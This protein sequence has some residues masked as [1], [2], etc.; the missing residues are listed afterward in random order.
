MR[1]VVLLCRHSESEGTF[2]FTINK[3]ADTKL[4]ELIEDVDPF[5]FP[6]LIGGP[7]QV[8]TLHYIHQYPDL[9]PDSQEVVDGVY[10]GG[11]FDALKAH[12]WT[13]EI[14]ADKIKFILGYSG[15]GAGQ[16]TEELSQKSWLTVEAN[17]KIVLGTPEADIWKESLLQLGGAYKALVN[18][19]VDPQLN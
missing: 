4:N 15:W 16:L 3:L 17:S 7:V 10:W 9:L 5:D 6:V 19:P 11:D 18:Y 12:L 2:G 14:T 13:G 1:T 8:D